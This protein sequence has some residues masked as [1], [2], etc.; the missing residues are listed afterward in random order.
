MDL[1]ND[2]A[3]YALMRFRKQFLYDEIEAEVSWTDIDMNTFVL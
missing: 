1:Y 3:Q 2:S